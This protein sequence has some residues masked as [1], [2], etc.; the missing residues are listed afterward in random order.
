MKLH[1]KYQS[2]CLL[3][4]LDLNDLAGADGITGTTT[5]AVLFLFRVPSLRPSLL[6][7]AIAT[8]GATSGASS[9]ATSWATSWATS[10]ATSRANS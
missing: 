7:D 5:S 3:R 4:P 9:G 1:A 10:R 8:S 6:P 2:L